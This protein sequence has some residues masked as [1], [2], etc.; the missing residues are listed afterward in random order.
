[1]TTT[2]RPWLPSLAPVGTN[3]ATGA[4]P[5]EKSNARIGP[6]PKLA[7]FPTIIG[8]EAIAADEVMTS[9][10]DVVSNVSKPNRSERPNHCNRALI[11]PPSVGSP[12]P[13]RGLRAKC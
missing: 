11:L 4:P 6:P 1:M 7:L 13:P 3:D 8:P 5:A 10:A 12:E 9:Q 2:P